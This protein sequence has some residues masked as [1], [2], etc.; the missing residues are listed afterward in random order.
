LNQQELDRVQEETADV[1]AQVIEMQ[2]SLVRIN[3]QLKESKLSALEAKLSEVQTQHAA[4]LDQR[5]ALQANDDAL[6]AIVD[7]EP[8]AWKNAQD[9]RNTDKRQYKKVEDVQREIEVKQTRKKEIDAILDGTAPKPAFTD[10]TVAP[11]DPK[12]LAAETL[13]LAG[14]LEQLNEKLSYLKQGIPDDAVDAYLNA[15]AAAAK[16]A[17]ERAAVAEQ[18]ASVSASIAAVIAQS[19]EVSAQIDTVNRESGLDGLPPIFQWP[20][21][22][23]VTAGYYDPDYQAV[24][25][26][27]HK[28]VDIAVPH[29]TAVHAIAEGVVFKVKLGGA[30]GYTYVLIGHRNG[31]ASLYGHLSQVYVKAG[32]LV[33]YTTVIG[34]SGGTPGTPGAGPMTTGAHVHVE[35]MENGEHINPLTV[36][37]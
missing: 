10:A 6:K 37:P 27:P 19:S 21:H 33:D 24:F 22:G 32:D 30:T 5:K 29:G 34:L 35:V 8:K 2:Q 28:A 31:Y 3:A 14:S 12:A 18:T 11:P 36:L 9:L 23:H 4:L 25:G 1:T 26:V 15:K 20:V 7:G 13:V 17:K 16:A